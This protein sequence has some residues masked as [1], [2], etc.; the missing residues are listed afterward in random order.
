[1]RGSRPKGPHS[2]PPPHMVQ[3][4]DFSVNVNYFTAKHLK[5]LKNL[6]GAQHQSSRACPL[7]MPKGLLPWA[8]GHCSC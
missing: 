7:W 2:P 5:R 1:M 6:L 4:Q 8:T 3:G